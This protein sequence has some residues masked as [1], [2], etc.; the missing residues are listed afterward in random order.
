M[1]YIVQTQR[2]DINADL[3]D[4]GLDFVPENAAELNFVV[5]Q[6]IAN[7]I[8][9]NGK[10]YSVLNEM[11]GALECCKLELQRVVIA[12]YEAEKEAQKGGVYHM[13]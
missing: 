1:P 8:Q 13:L 9:R 7:Y 6:L 11:V 4:E 2:N 12:P 3:C 10:R 5:S